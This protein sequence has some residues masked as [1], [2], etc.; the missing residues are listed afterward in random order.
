MLPKKIYLGSGMAGSGKDFVIDST[1]KFIFDEDNNATTN[2]IIKKDK[3]ANTMKSILMR[4]VDSSL[5]T[6][7]LE[8]IGSTFIDVDDDN[9]KKN[10][11]KDSE[12][13]EEGFEFIKNGTVK[14]DIGHGKDVTIREMLQNLGTEVIRGI[15]KDFHV[16]MLARR[17]IDAK[18]SVIVIPDARFDNEFEFVIRY[19][20]L[21]SEGER[22]SYLVDISTYNSST[23]MD[24]VSNSIS[25]IYD[26]PVKESGYIN[27]IKKELNVLFNNVA[28]ITD[29]YDQTEENKNLR[30]QERVDES[31]CDFMSD[32]ESGVVFV[33]RKSDRDMPEGAPHPSEIKAI[34]KTK[35]IDSKDGRDELYC[36]VNETTPIGDNPQFLVLVNDVIKVILDDLVDRNLRNFVDINDM[37]RL[38]DPVLLKLWIDSNSDIEEEGAPMGMVGEMD[39]LCDKYIINLGTLKRWKIQDPDKAGIKKP[40]SPKI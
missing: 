23:D 16:K 4:L 20:E 33:K 22:R 21:K 1:K 36:F 39:S 26:N 9:I 7:V 37:D 10:I 2:D 15:D 35:I 17:L 40:K 14:F 12:I 11:F 25:M 27:H 32:L 18:S 19:N 5:K 34:E 8:N 28:Y 6:Q 13:T 3:F 24:D 30:D 31:K 29:D 38:K